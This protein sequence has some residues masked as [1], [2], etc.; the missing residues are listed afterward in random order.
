MTDAYVGE[1]QVFGFNYA[2][3]GWAVC[4]GQLLAVQQFTALFSLLGTYYGGDG[5]RTFALPNF[6]DNNFANGIA[7]CSQ[8]QGPGL[9]QR[10]IGEPFGTVQATLNITQMPS[11]THPT[12]LYAQPDTSKRAAAPQAGYGVVTPGNPTAFV[13]ATPNT[14]FAATTIGMNGGNQPHENRQ[15]YLGLN[16]CICLQGIYPSFN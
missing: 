3:R 14:S 7:P 2:P 9:S 5:A 10:T 8:G 1:I 11:H 12:T 15:P 4:N 13:T 16:I 6:Y